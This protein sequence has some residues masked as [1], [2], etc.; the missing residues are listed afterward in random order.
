[1]TSLRSGVEALTGT[2]NVGFYMIHLEKAVERLPIIEKLENNINTKLT[3]IPG[4]DGQ[5]LVNAGHPVRCLDDINSNRSPGDI[6]C[7]VSHIRTLKDGLAAGYD[8]IVLF[9]DDCEVTG[10]IEQLNRELQMFKNL[11]IPFDLFM[12]D[13][14]PHNITPCSIPTFTRIYKFDETH[15]YVVSRKFAIQFIDVY[16]KCCSLNLTYAIDGLISKVLLENKV[17]SYGFSQRNKFFRQTKGLVSYIR[18]R[19][20]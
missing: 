6:G 4:S 9:E 7:T 19:P 2:K 14:S 1:M 17:T 16:E 10:S 3:L 15:A 5:E 20:R 13:C 12:L 8:Y 18:G 11:N